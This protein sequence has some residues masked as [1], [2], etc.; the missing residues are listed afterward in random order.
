MRRVQDPRLAIAHAEL[1]ELYREQERLAGGN[2]VVAAN[3]AK[4]RFEGKFEMAIREAETSSALE[5]LLHLEFL[6]GEEFRPICPPRLRARIER[7]I[8]QRKG[9]EANRARK[10]ARLRSAVAH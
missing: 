4:N 2:D 5:E 8:V 6:D 9:A 1:I 3:A 10:D 7:T